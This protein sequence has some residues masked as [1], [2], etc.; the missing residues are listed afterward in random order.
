MLSA[1]GRW[2]ADSRDT[3]VPLG[4]LVATAAFLFNVITEALRWRA[5]LSAMYH[6]SGAYVHLGPA[7]ASKPLSIVLE[8]GPTAPTLERDRH[9]VLFRNQS[10]RATAILDAFPLTKDRRPLQ[11]AKY[12]HRG[13]LP[14][15]IPPWGLVKTFIYF[16]ESDEA[17][18]SWIRFRD[19]HGAEIDVQVK[20][21]SMP[22]RWVEPRMDAEIP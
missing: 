7:P 5:R 8:A 1:I 3:I 6:G 16:D 17:E 19:M 20:I 4:V 9:V 14:L 18:A 12:R 21:A 15:V 22:P 2:L 11:E 10:H 13:G